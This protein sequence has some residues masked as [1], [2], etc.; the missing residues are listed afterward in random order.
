[1]NKDGE[2]WPAYQKDKA[3]LS[4][5]ICEEEFQAHLFVHWYTL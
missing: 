2:G 1:M 5:A 4:H 3:T